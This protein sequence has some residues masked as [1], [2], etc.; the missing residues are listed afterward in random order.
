M[1]VFWKRH[2][3]LA[4]GVLPYLLSELLKYLLTFFIPL[5][6]VI[7]YP[8]K[9]REGAECEKK[10]MASELFCSQAGHINCAPLPNFLSIDP[11]HS[12]KLCLRACHTPQKREFTDNV[13]LEKASLLDCLYQASL[14]L[15]IIY[16]PKRSQLLPKIKET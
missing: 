13:V 15:N 3:L 9:H 6:I 5:M 12:K 11:W 4:I 2:I 14:F 7:V 16:T 10:N 8:K 1:I